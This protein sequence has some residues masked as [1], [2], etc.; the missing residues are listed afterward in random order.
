MSRVRT[1]KSV[2]E[3]PPIKPLG[4]LKIQDSKGKLPCSLSIELELD[5]YLFEYLV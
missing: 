1:Q 5:L 4:D 3:K 2:I